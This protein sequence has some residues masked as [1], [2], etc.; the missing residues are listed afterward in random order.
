MNCEFD[1]IR[2]FAAGEVK[3]AVESLLADRQFS[4]ILK[5]FVPAS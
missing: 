1:E 2:P 5:G 3:G 4:R